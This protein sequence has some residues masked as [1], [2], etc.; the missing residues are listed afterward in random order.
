MWALSPGDVLD[1]KSLVSSN[2]TTT[3]S[4]VGPQEIA[5]TKRIGR[6]RAALVFMLSSPVMQCI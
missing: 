4:V 6:K 5:P 2:G 1:V 3:V